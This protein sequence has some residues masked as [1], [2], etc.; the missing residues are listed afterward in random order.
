M[1]WGLSRGYVVIPKASDLGHQEDN[2][3]ALDFALAPEDVA[4]ITET[5]DEGKQLFLHTPDQKY[6]VYA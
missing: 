5:L 1:N 2:F 4:E 6:N 3:K